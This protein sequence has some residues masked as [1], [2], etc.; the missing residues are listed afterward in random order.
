MQGLGDNIYQ[1]AFVR[2]IP[3]RVYLHTPWPQIYVDLPHV[4]PVRPKT[5]LRTQC[6]NID[7]MPANMWHVAP[8]LPARRVRYGGK[9]FSRGS[10]LDAMERCLRVRP[11]IFDLPHFDG[12]EIQRPYAIVRPVTERKEWTNVAR[13]P[14]SQYVSEAADI[15][16]RFGMRTVCVAD[17]DDGAEW[18]DELPCCDDE[19]LHGELKFEQLMGLIQGAEIV[20]GGVGWIVPAA[21]AAGV[22][23]LCILGGQGGH[24]APEKITGEPMNLSKTRWIYPDNFCRCTKMLHSCDKTITDF[25]EKF[26]EACEDLCLKI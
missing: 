13:N 22:P 21:I 10:I 4:F 25:G 23:L 5:R 7:R 6:K 15:I 1:R 17:L 19:Y 26:K 24:N 18:A 8:A 12:P 14:Y 11:K 16:R 9:E 2:E 3:E 20:V